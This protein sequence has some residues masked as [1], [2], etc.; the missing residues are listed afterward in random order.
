[1]SDVDRGFSL[2]CVSDGRDAPDREPKNGILSV[3]TLSTLFFFFFSAVESSAEAFVGPFGKVK[4][5][6][7]KLVSSVTGGALMGAVVSV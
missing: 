6:R 7:R 3:K 5:W 2:C 1:M 4:R